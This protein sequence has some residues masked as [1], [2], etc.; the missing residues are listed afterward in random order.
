[1]IGKNGQDVLTLAIGR[2]R[3]ALE[4][5]MACRCAGVAEKCEQL[6][7]VEEAFAALAALGAVPELRESVE[8]AQRL[9]KTALETSISER[10]KRAAAAAARAN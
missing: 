5:M 6:K 2:V 1:M 9:I 4:A 10:E 3:D 8:F 7:G